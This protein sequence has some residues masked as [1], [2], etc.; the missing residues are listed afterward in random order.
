MIFNLKQLFKKSDFTENTTVKPETLSVEEIPLPLEGMIEGHNTPEEVATYYNT[1]TDSYKESFGLFFQAMQATDDAAFIAYLAESMGLR[2]G[3]RVLDAGC[4]IGGPML[5]FAQQFT[6]DIEGVTISQKQV[7]E[8]NALFAQ[9]AATLKAGAKVQ[10]KLGDFH[11]L[12]E[13]Y[14]PNSFDV[15]YFME[16]LCHAIDPEAVIAGA[17]KILKKEGIIYIKDLHRGPDKPTDF[18][19]TDFP[20]NAINQGFCLQIRPVGEIIDLLGKY[21]FRLDFCR[22]P[23]FEQSF[24]KGNAFTAK[25]LYKLLKD[26]EGPWVDE[27]IIFL[28]WLETRAFKWY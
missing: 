9:E 20:V 21:G 8:A 3:L 28:N 14:P 23:T 11:K 7:D 16:S 19:F 2:D 17:S 27:G 1:W 26:Q 13:M 4:G 18:H 22:F 15:V 24:D 6:L 12:G 10:V 5:H 25:H